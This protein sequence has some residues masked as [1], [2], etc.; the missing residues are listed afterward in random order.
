MSVWIVSLRPY[1]QLCRGRSVR[2]LNAPI[3]TFLTAGKGSRREIAVV[4]FRVP[5]RLDAAHVR[6]VFID[7]MRNAH[8]G[9]PVCSIISQAASPWPNLSPFNTAV[10]EPREC[11]F[12]AAVE[13]LGF[14]SLGCSF[15]LDQLLSTRPGQLVVGGGSSRP[16]RPAALLQVIALFPG[17]R[18]LLQDCQVRFR[19]AVLQEFLHTDQ[20]G[21]AHV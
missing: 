3:E 8:C 12:N 6:F 1:T 10:C 15:G 14:S 18:D 11:R 21:R 17:R 2:W 20:I 13:V 5:T 7:V 16:C 9:V 19:I 4:S